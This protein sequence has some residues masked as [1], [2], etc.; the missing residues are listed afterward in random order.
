MPLSKVRD[1]INAIDKELLPLFIKRMKCSEEVAEIKIANNIPVLNSTREKEIIESIKARATGYEKEAESL[2][3]FIMALS[4]NRQNELFSAEENYFTRLIK[5]SATTF[6]SS[7]KVI[8][9]GVEGAYSHKAASELFPNSELMFCPKFEEVFTALDN[10]VCDFGVIPMEN[11]TA[12]SVTETYNLI[13]RYRYYIVGSLKLSVSHCLAAKKGSDV[14][15][16]I[17]H[18]QALMQ[19]DNF[20]KDGGF[21]A[22]EFS[23]T[24]AAA[25]FVSETSD[26][27][28]AAICSKDAAEKYGLSI[29]KEGI[30]DNKNNHT[31]FAVISKK[32]ILPENADTISLC[33][34]V[35]N[36]AGSLYKVLERFCMAGL[37]L[38][39]IESR[40]IVGSDFDYD[41]YLDFKGNIRQKEVSA[42][43]AEFKNELIRFDFLGN[44]VGL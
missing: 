24:A 4:K 28:I 36:E 40:P 11:S 7:S 18:P 15:K 29:I 21:I 38:S 32:A 2:Y 22:E 13:M 12:G 6:P 17:S 34:S 35:P 30:Q 39:K 44:Y 9:Q 31:R 3:S 1:E 42:I 20:I 19:C 16:I 37:N 27:N 25:K 23:N 8:C 5:G 10:G 33:F 41:F 14:K 43:L 26:M